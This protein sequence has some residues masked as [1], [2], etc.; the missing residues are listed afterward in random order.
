MAGQ[1]ASSCADSP[2]VGLLLHTFADGLAV[3][4]AIFIY[5]FHIYTNLLVSSI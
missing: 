5:L 4:I 1:T 2:V 3:G